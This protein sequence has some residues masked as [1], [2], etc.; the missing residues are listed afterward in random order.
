MWNKNFTKK[1]L[2]VLLKNVSSDKYFIIF[3]PLDDSHVIMYHKIYNRGPEH[4]RIAIAMCSAFSFN[5]PEQLIQSCTHLSISILVCLGAWLWIIRQTL[6]NELSIRWNI[7]LYMKCLLYSETINS[8]KP[9]GI[10]LHLAKMY[11]GQIQMQG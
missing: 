3:V 9:S 8:I 2:F 5:I 4:I 10:T 11:S 7:F 1:V 6:A